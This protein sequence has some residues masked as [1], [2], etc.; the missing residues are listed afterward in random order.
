MKEEDEEEF[1]GEDYDEDDDVSLELELSIDDFIQ[2][3]KFK[4]IFES[5]TNQE[6]VVFYFTQQNDGEPFEIKL[7]RLFAIKQLLKERFGDTPIEYN[8]QVLKL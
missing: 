8:G 5:K 3:E 1:D 7:Y 6:L 2:V 4:G